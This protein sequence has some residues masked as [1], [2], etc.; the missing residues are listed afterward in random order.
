[1]AASR[2]VACIATGRRRVL[3]TG[4]GAARGQRL[5]SIFGRA[6]VLQDAARRRFIESACAGDPGLRLEIERLVEADDSAQA[7]GF[8]EGHASVDVDD[9]D[10]DENCAGRSVGPYTIVRLLGHGG[11]GK[12]FLAHRSDVDT[13]VAVKLLDSTFASSDAIRRFLFERTVLGR[14]EHPH[15]ARLLDAGIVHPNTPY[16]VMEFVDGEPIIAHA[17]RLDMRARLRLFADVCSAIAYAHR[18]LVVHR[19]LKPSNIM[20]DREGRVKVVDFGIAKLLDDDHELTRTGSRLMT[21]EFAAPEQVRG[22]P[23]T[24]ATDVYALGLVLFELLTGTRAYTLAGLTPAQ[25]ERRVCDWTPPR[26]STFDAS[27]RG[28]LDA[29]CLRALEKD[30]ARRYP[31]GADLLADVQ[32][33][34][35]ERPV[36]ARTPT[37]FYVS[38][39]FIARHRLA[40]TTAALV[41]ALLVC[42]SLAILW[43]AGRAERER[44]RAE[45]ALVESDAIAD[46][47]IELFDARDP[48]Q[49]RGTDPSAL[50]L[51]K[52]G[53]ARAEQLASQPLVQARMLDTIGRVYYMLGQYDRAEPPAARALMVRQQHLPRDHPDTATSLHNLGLLHHEQGRFGDAE[54][55]FAAA[56]AMRR[57]VLGSDHPDVADTLRRYGLLVL[58]LRHDDRTAEQMFQEA[59]AIARRAFGQDDARVAAMLNTLAAVYDF[60][61]D[62]ETTE[63]ILSEALHI[64]RQRLGASHPDAIE[65]LHNLSTTFLF[66]GDLRRA[67]AIITETLELTRQV[68]GGDHPRVASA[69]SVLATTAER[70]GQLTR[71]DATFREAIAVAE[72]AMGTDHPRVAQ[73]WGSRARVLAQLGR[74][75]EAEQLNIRAIEVL[76]RKLGNTHANVRRVEQQLAALRGAE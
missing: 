46:F 68:F 34:L 40:V 59:V 36:E 23:I 54:T 12:V 25:A 63:R 33:F 52:R 65:T 51:I 2:L 31:T 11:M 13:H 19:D 14:L 58:R 57:R 62:Y 18:R 32:R 75:A 8:L 38:R 45:R 64:Q 17:A 72:A 9:L 50:D 37:L 3:T 20:V 42:G 26:P 56:L 30:A 48:A 7:E 1:M 44:A 73:Y 61:D 15:I 41:A 22:E 43:Q 27:A 66:R 60:R 47:L 28:D 6:I 29:I 4:S 21:P 16:F 49:S 67:E 69:L 5:L 74:R 76:R 70:D 35:D 71:A 24:P 53:E 39:K 10:E 55:R